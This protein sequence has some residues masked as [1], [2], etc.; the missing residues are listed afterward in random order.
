M[1]RCDEDSTLFVYGSLIDEARR[2]ELLGRPV[3]TAPA[4]LRDYALGRARY[5]YIIRQPDAVITG[6]LLLDLNARD[7]I[8]LDRYE[9]LPILYT[10]EKIEVA[11]AAGQPRRCWV[12]LPT[13]RTLRGE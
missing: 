4:T 11:D 3:A 12:Y 10:R 2:M 7:F 6:L 1:P 13:A 9:E 8:E 5:F